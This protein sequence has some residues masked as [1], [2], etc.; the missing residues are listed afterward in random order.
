MIRNSVNVACAWMALVA[1]LFAIPAAR[2][3]STAAQSDDDDGGFAVRDGD[4]GYIDSAIL[5]NVLRF[6][7]DAADDFNRP[8]RAEFFYARARPEGSGLPRSEVAIDYQLG[9]L[10]AEYKTHDLLSLFVELGVVA[11]NPILNENTAGLGDMNAGCKVC[12]LETR[13]FLATAQLRV[14]AP[15]ADSERGLGNGHVSIEPRF[16]ATEATELSAGVRSASYGTGPRWEV[17][18]LPVI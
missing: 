12:L 17:R 13:S 3:Q 5:G 1:C 18:I 7:F 16:V 2:G 15:T 10:Y 8:N 9:S 4:V 6:R 11:L 14:Y